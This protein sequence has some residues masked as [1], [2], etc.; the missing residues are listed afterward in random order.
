M[1]RLCFLLCV[2]GLCRPKGLIISNLFL[3]LLEQ[4]LVELVQCLPIF[5]R[6]H[7]YH[8][9][10]PW[11]VLEL[12][13]QAAR[14]AGH[15]LPLELRPDAIVL[16]E[17]REDAHG[18]LVV[19][20]LKQVLRLLQDGVLDVGVVVDLVHDHSLVEEI[21]E[22]V[23]VW[24]THEV[25]NHLTSVDQKDCGDAGDLEAVGNLRELVDVYL[26]ELKPALVSLGYLL[27][28]WGQLF[29]WTAPTE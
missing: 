9:L 10:G 26:D 27:K 18:C 22:A 23:A 8:L 17:V 28:H 5:R 24:D 15:H 6:E 14:D 21:L 29:A 7:L 2:R 19:F 3:G 13:H 12:E 25:V 20:G 1:H 11:V 16:N 4:P